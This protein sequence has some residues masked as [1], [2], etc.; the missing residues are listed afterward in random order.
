MYG[1]KIDASRYKKTYIIYINMCWNSDISLN[2]FI[3]A[4]FALSFIYITNTYSKYKSPEF[5]NPLIYLLLFEVALIQLVEFFLWRNLKNDNINKTLSIV[6]SLIILSQLLTLILMIP[7]KVYKY[8]MLL[9]G[10]M[11]LLVYVLYK[12]FY[13]PFVFRATVGPNGHLVWGWL[14]QKG[15]GHLFPIGIGLLYG[16]PVF[17]LID[18]IFVITVY[19]A[20]TL[21]VSAVMYYKHNTVASMWCWSGNLFLLYFIIN[22]LL[23][24]PFYEYNGLC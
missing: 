12:H 19:G 15:W 17:L 11:F 6:T 21:L 7:N 5:N 22:I 13:D 20:I 14:S 10:G 4:C 2:S 8:F 9:F 3:F 18:K 1:V 24:Q 16:I 23:I